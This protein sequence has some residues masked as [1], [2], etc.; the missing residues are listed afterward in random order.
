MRFISTDIK[1]NF[2]VA[3]VIGS[4]GILFSLLGVLHVAFTAIIPIL[5]MFVFLAI[6][7]K[8]RSK[9]FVAN[10]QL[11]D[12]FY[13]LG[14]LFTLTSLMTGLIGFWGAIDVETKLLGQFGVAI[15]TTIIGLAG[16]IILSQFRRPT[17]EL[18]QAA[19][20]QLAQNVREFKIQLDSSIDMYRQFTLDLKSENEKTFQDHTAQYTSYLKRSIEEF[21]KTNLEIIN[22]VKKASDEFLNIKD[23]IKDFNAV[24]NNLTQNLS[25]MNKDIQSINSGIKTVVNIFDKNDN[26]SLANIKEGLET[27]S[28]TIKQ[29]SEN[30]ENYQDKISK[31]LDVINTQRDDLDKEIDKSRDTIKKTYEAMAHMTK[32]LHDKL[33]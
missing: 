11:G 27:L 29:K 32:F 8:F 31:S 25:L 19:E 20:T 15:S 30:I 2:I 18:T 21:G 13:Y 6:N 28:S 3:Y 4:F 9:H 23:S 10:E 26:N 5:V 24:T 12:S 22:E 16:R 17:E 33:K 1:I 14:F 7:I